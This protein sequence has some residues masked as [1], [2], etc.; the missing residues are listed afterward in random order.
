[1]LVKA[2]LVL[3]EVGFLDVC[4]VFTPDIITRLHSFEM[5]AFTD[6]A[7]L[8]ENL[9]DEGLVLLYQQS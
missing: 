3:E 4:E 9:M 1:M 8:F 2:E 7:K 6:A 5:N